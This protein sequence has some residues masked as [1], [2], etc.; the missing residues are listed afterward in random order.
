MD[1]WLVMGHL[2]VER[3]KGIE[4]LQKVIVRLET[5]PRLTTLNHRI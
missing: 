1:Q 4:L 2:R 3:E 5:Q